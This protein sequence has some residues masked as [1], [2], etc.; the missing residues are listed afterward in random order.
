MLHIIYKY[1]KIYITIKIREG[2]GLPYGSDSKKSA[3]NAG[4]LGL[5]PG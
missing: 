3:Y 2:L 5:I 1:I 4:D